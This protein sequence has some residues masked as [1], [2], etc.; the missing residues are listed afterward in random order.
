MPPSSIIATHDEQHAFVNTVLYLIVISSTLIC[1]LQSAC[2]IG[3]HALSKINCMNWVFSDSEHCQAMPGA[4]LGM[5]SPL[6]T[7]AVCS[8]I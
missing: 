1:R 8:P 6:H 7:T 3:C 2:K 4:S 5:P